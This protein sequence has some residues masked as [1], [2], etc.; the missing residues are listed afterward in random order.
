MIELSAQLEVISFWTAYGDGQL[1]F[2]KFNG[3]VGWMQIDRFVATFTTLDTGATIT[4]LAG[5]VLKILLVSFK[6]DA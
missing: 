6:I 2:P 1:A 5:N 4:Q 3:G